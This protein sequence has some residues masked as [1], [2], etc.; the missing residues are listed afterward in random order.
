MFEFFVVIRKR[1]L[2]IDLQK[3]QLAQPVQRNLTALFEGQRDE[4]LSVETELKNFEP[5]YKLEKDELFELRDFELPGIFTSA[6]AVPQ[7]ISELDDAFE[8]TAPIVKAIVAVD[9]EDQ[10]FYFQTFNRGHILNRKRTLLLNSNVFQQLEIPAVQIDSKLA[11]VFRDGNLYFRSFFATKQ[12]LPME[13]IF[14]EATNED[15]LTVLGHDML[16]VNSSESIVTD[17][18]PRSRK[19]FSLIIASGILDNPKVTPTV[20]QRRSKKFPGLD[21][22]TKRL[23]GALKIIFPEGK[24]EIELLLRFLAEEFYVS[25]ITRQPRATNS[26]EHYQVPAGS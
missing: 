23:N 8:T 13:E 1:D 11:A 20:V 5:T 24:G 6:L 2:E 4:F 18:A 7:G 10:A 3:I 16:F 19:K 17:L 14:D 22:R 21:V 15:V 25:E 26:H 12:F 9:S